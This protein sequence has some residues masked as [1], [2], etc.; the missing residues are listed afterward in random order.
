MPV[1]PAPLCARGAG[2]KSGALLGPGL[3]RCREH[4]TT[5]ASLVRLNSVCL[6]AKG[7]GGDGK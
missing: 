7:K 4:T 2:N 3:L 6:R 1:G 5:L